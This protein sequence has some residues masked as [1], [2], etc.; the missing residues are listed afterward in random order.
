MAFSNLRYLD[1]KGVSRRAWQP[2]KDCH[3]HLYQY[4]SFYKY[5]RLE[6]CNSCLTLKIIKNVFFKFTIFGLS[7]GC[8]EGRGN[9]L[10]AA[11]PTYINISASINNIDLKFATV[12][13]PFLGIIKYGIFKFTIPGL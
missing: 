13:Y 5:Y 7:R 8:L 12:T 4:L 6:I 10:K 1:Y 2:I 9:L 11:S 3:T